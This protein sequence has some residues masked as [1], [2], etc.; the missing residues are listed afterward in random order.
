MTIRELRKRRGRLIQL[1]LDDG[2][3]VTVDIRTFEESPY[4]VGSSLSDEELLRLTDESAQRRVKE[5]ALYLLSMRDHSRAELEQKLRREGDSDAA[6][7]TAA[8]MEELGLINDEV[9]ARR[10]ARDLAE[11]KRYSCRHTMQELGARGID[12]LTI[13]DVMAELDLDD[14]QQALALLNK[15]YYNKKNDENS[16]PKVAAA[17]GRAGFDGET[18]RRAMREWQSEEQDMDTNGF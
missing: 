14:A 17:L 7:S 3:A 6:S 10:L 4:G 12:R 5:K 18:I 16:L 2:S 8:R 1:V 11:R 15:K 9:F 13:Q